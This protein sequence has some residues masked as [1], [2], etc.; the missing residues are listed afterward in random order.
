V[1]LGEELG[2]P[3]TEASPAGP[4][5]PAIHTVKKTNH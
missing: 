1:L 2:K 3:T 4:L 5:V